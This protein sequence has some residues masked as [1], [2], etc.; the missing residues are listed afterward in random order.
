MPD[1]HTS[2]LLFLAGCVSWTI[3]TFS[4]GSGSVVLL[5]LVT[6]L[7]RL[8]QV[9]PVLT[10][11]SLMVSPASIALSAAGGMAS[12]RMVF[13]RCHRRGHAGRLAPEL[14][15][16][17]L[18]HP[19]RRGVPVSNAMRYHLGERVRSFPMRL[20]CFIPVSVV[21]GLISGLV[22]ASSLVSLPFYLNYV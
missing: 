3:S 6:H 20:P 14:G 11:A 10:I 4:G 21:V 19:N 22:G 7:I 2:T 5:A 13:A 18:A 9:A 15:T 12:G 8:T 17:R 16:N 1:F